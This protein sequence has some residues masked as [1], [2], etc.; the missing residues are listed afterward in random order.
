MGDP[1]IILCPGQGAQ[2]VG[3]AKAWHDASPEARATFEEADRLLGDLF[4]SPL[5]TICFSGPADLLNRTDVSQPAIYVAGVACWR[6]ILAQTSHGNGEIP[7]AA[8][9]GLSLGEYTALYVAGAISFSD[10]LELVTLRGRAMQDAAESPEAIAGGGGGMVAL[11]GAEEP[12]AQLIC[13]EARAG[14]VLVCANFNAPGQIVLSGHKRACERAA[15]I[16]ANAGVRAAMLAVSGAFHSPLMA[17]AAERLKAA[18]ER[19]SIREPR[20]PVLSNVTGLPHAPAQGRGLVELIR[21]R[22]VAQLTSPVRWAEDCR[23][24]INNAVGEMHELAPGKTLSGLMRRVDRGAKV[25]N[26]EEP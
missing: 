25:V 11:V 16:A 8:T 18:L 20:C 14:D 2:A 5:S 7:L 26:H 24:I 22:L 13:D 3:M 15:T 6:A 12:Q 21:A 10:G 19:V 4:G 1:L 9:A 17:S 23:W